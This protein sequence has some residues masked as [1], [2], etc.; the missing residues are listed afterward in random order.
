M[1]NNLQNMVPPHGPRKVKKAI[2]AVGIMNFLS[3]GQNQALSRRDTPNQGH[4][5]FF[6]TTSSSSLSIRKSFRIGK[7]ESPFK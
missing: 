6:T 5:V 4:I 3:V 2:A 1:G 7:S